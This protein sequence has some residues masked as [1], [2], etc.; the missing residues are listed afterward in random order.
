[1][2]LDESDS[3]RIESAFSNLASEEQLEVLGWRNVPVEPD[4][5]G[6]TYKK[7][8]AKKTAVTP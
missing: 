3:V 5:L 8:L 2:F 4:N 6:I 1:V 7:R